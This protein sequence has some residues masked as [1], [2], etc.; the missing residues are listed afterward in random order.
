MTARFVDM[1]P[2]F[3]QQVMNSGHSGHLEDSSVDQLGGIITHVSMFKA[4]V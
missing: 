1:N 2:K 3:E 4:I